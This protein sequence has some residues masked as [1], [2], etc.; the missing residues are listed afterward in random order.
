MSWWNRDPNTQAGLGFLDLD[1]TCAVTE[2][3]LGVRHR[4]V[5]RA[6][7]RRESRDFISSALGFAGRLPPDPAQGLGVW[8]GAAWPEPSSRF[9]P[10][11]SAQSRATVRRPA[12][13]A[14]LPDHRPLLPRGLHRASRWR[15]GANT[16]RA[17]LASLRPRPEA[18]RASVGCRCTTVTTNC[19]VLIHLPSLSLI[20]ARVD[21]FACRQSDW[22]M[23][24][25]LWALR[26]R[27]PPP[28]S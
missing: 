8:A 1:P 26:F 4:P 27:Q 10:A 25:G 5:W 21:A 3:T 9:P 13:G 6:L 20:L 17:G 15:A 23:T 28:A 11:S 19:C 22:G 2:A 14:N 7:P 24:A 18:R 12:A 16:I